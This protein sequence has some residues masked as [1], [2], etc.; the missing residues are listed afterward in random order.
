MLADTAADRQLY[1]EIGLVPVQLR[2]LRHRGARQEEQRQAHQR[3]VDVGRGGELSGDRRTGR[4]RRAARPGTR[5]QRAE[6]V[7]PGRGAGGSAD[8]AR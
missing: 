2:P 1:L 4:R 6:E 5:L 3:A 7:D 8:G